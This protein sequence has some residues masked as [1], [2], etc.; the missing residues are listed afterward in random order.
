MV[1]LGTQQVLR[2]GQ[3]PSLVI[4]H[5]R[6]SCHLS[7]NFLYP[8]SQCR[9]GKVTCDRSA[10][11]VACGW[12]AWSQWTPCDTVCGSGM[13]ERFRC[14][15]AY[16]MVICGVRGR[17]AVIANHTAFSSFPGLHLILPAPMGEL[18]V[19]ATR[20]TSQSATLRVPMVGHGTPQHLQYTPT[21][22]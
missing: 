12:S 3:R 9:D 6:P 22:S 16:T 7:H 4:R 2:D 15:S 17:H 5:P 19:R 8:N 13:Q 11:A 10:C 18:H 14:D 21:P 1:V 20:G